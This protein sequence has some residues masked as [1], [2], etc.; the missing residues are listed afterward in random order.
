MMLIDGSMTAYNLDKALAD[1]TARGDMDTCIENGSLSCP[2]GVATKGHSVS[3]A[4]NAVLRF[5]RP[6]GR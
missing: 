1:G 3:L 4:D 2:A 5:G 6:A